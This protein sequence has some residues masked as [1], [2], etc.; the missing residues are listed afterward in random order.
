[1]ARH[2]STRQVNVGLPRVTYR[3]AAKLDST[4]SS[5]ARIA[6][7]LAGLGPP[8]NTATSLNESR[9]PMRVRICSRPSGEA[10]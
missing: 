10:V 4:D 5:V 7:A 2:K 1:M 6:W 3:M 8:S 9:G